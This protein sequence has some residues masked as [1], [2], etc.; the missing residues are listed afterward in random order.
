VCDLENLKNEEAMTR[1]GSQR[2]RKKNHKNGHSSVNAKYLEYYETVPHYQIVP[3][4]PHMTHFQAVHVS[5]VKT[6]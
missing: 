4:L 3:P 2:H 5:V 1:I 6:F